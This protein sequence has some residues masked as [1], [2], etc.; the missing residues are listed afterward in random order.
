MSA[1]KP[2]SG[3][4][5]GG[6]GG[7]GGAGGALS[8]ADQIKAMID[9]AKAANHSFMMTNPQLVTGDA[10]KPAQHSMEAI[11]APPGFIQRQV[12]RARPFRLT[13]E[14]KLEESALNKG[15]WKVKLS[16]ELSGGV[17][18]RLRPMMEAI[19]KTFEPYFEANGFTVRMPGKLWK[20]C[21]DKQRST[22]EWAFEKE[23]SG[24]KLTKAEAGNYQFW[25]LP[26]EVNAVTKEG[27]A[28]PFA[29]LKSMFNDD[30]AMKNPNGK[31]DDTYYN[32]QPFGKQTVGKLA[33]F[34]LMLPK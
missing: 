21:A 5:A 8:Q 26:K 11:E 23:L 24:K 15:E 18:A 7:G 34:D 31:I 25:V 13:F 9:Q 28:S 6:T 2:A 14:Q 32:F 4:T 22:V 3:G 19:S 33:I 1:R 17:F 20:V 27:A 29:L 16:V 10:W 12:E 30:K